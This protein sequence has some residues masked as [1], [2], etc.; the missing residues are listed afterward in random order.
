MPATQP[1]SA[2]K[3]AAQKNAEATA[4]LTPLKATVSPIKAP[5]TPI[6]PKPSKKPATKP[7]MAV[8]AGPAA[9]LDAKGNVLPIRPAAYPEMINHPLN[10]F[11]CGET[12]PAPAFPF[13]TKK[14]AGQGRLLECSKCW[15]SRIANNKALKAAGKPTVPAPRATVTAPPNATA[16]ITA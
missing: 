15:V 9:T 11:G 2:R 10:C 4:A 12:K 16:K 13:V 3:T 5:K 14:G 1:K 8:F 7:T 6:A